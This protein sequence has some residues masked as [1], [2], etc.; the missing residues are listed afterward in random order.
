[1]KNLLKNKLFFVFIIFSLSGCVLITR[2]KKETKERLLF[3]HLQSWNEFQ[4]EGIIEANY[5]GFALRKNV[6]IRKKNDIF[7]IDV[8]DSG[9]MGM[10]PTPFLSIYIDSVMIVRP[11]FSDEVITA[12]EAGMTDFDSS[13]FS[14]DTNLLFQEKDTIISRLVIEYPEYQ[15]YFSDKMQ[16]EKIVTLKN[17]ISIVF[18]YIDGLDQ[19]SV[20]QNEKQLANIQIDKIE[21]K[22]I[23]IPILK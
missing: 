11:P 5:Q 1:M 3:E 13:L 7:R 21:H 10:K 20:L 2:P 16:I 23:E 6:M 15:I 9:F 14:F 4:I 18:N 19:I 17:P 22:N 12:A 8:Y